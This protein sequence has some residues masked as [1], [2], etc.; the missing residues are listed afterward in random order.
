MATLHSH[1]P[2]ANYARHDCGA[3]LP[4]MDALRGVRPSYVLTSNGEAT[5]QF[6]VMPVNRWSLINKW[7]PVLDGF[8]SGIHDGC[9]YRRLLPLHR[10]NE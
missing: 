3:D 10:P 7:V 4:V 2:A 5:I 6:L 1:Y 9:W 8:C